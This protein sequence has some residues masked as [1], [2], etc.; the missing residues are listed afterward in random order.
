MHYASQPYTLKYD[1]SFFKGDL[2]ELG[3]EGVWGQ[4]DKFC[5]YQSPTCHGVTTFYGIATSS[6]MTKIWR[7]KV[8]RYYSVR[9]KIQG[10]KMTK[11]GDFRSIFSKVLVS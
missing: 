10:G 1:N 7:A 4:K 2:K 5:L 9:Y 6:F 8:R 11:N 3:Q